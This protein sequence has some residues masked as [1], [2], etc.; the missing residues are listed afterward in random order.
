[1]DYD[2]S[3]PWPF[4]ASLMIGFAARALSDS[5]RIDGDELDDVRWF[6]R[7]QLGDD[8]KT[9]DVILPPD[10]SLARHLIDGWYRKGVGPEEKEHTHD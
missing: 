10:I 7:R 8:I 6:S 9:G 1:M 3:Q 5:I 2:S 4:P